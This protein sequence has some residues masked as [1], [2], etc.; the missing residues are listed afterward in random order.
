ML[1]KT[2]KAAGIGFLLGIVIGNLIAFLTGN[3]DTGGITF[4]PQELL[5][6][7]GGNAVIAMLLQ[8]LFS[9]LYG[10]VCFAG[11][12]FYEIERMPLAVATA[13]H[14]ALIVLLFIPIALLLG[15]VSQ[16]E[17]QLMI[18]GIQLVCFFIIWLIMYAGFK[19]QVKELNELQEKNENEE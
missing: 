16:I 9:G 10:A 12:S 2:L 15:W 14:C 7:S 4:A 3:S 11:M 18:S 19:K 1:K 17:T 13:L 5:D 8:S 6:M